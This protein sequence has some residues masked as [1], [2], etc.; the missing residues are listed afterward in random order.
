MKKTILLVTLAILALGISIAVYAADSGPAHT[1]QKPA[2]ACQHCTQPE[3]TTTAAEGTI[4]KCACGEKCT[5]GETGGCANSACADACGSTSAA[6]AC[7]MQGG[8][9]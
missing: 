1:T 9:H 2:V 6:P 4:T 7:G 5:C 3:V 8:C